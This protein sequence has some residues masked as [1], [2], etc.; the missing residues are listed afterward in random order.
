MCISLRTHST[1]E[2]NQMFTKSMPWRHLLWGVIHQSTFY[3]VYLSVSWT[4]CS[5]NMGF[6]TMTTMMLLNSENN[7]FPWQLI[8]SSRARVNKPFI[9]INVAKCGTEDV[10][11]DHCSHY[12]YWSWSNWNQVAWNSNPFYG[13]YIMENRW[14]LGLFRW[15]LTF[16]H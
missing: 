14:K 6:V 8:N 5:M 2:V 12:Y 4:H 1:T 15:S 16:K 11:W 3:V 9:A 10:A 13:C 7:F